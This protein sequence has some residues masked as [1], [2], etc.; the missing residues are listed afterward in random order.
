[1]AGSRRGF[2]DEADGAG[3]AVALTEV[4]NKVTGRLHALIFHEPESGRIERFNR[5]NGVD[6][7]GSPDAR[8]LEDNANRTKT[9]VES[10]FKTC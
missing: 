8:G 4:S 7:A 9:L 10:C 5:F 1:M 2:V 3:A 6:L